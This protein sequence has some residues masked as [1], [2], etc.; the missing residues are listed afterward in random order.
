MVFKGLILDDKQFYQSFSNFFQEMVK[1]LGF[2]DSFDSSN[3][4]QSDSVNNAIRK[5]ENHLR[6]KKVRQT[7]TTTSTFHFPDVDKADIENVISILNSSK[8]G[9]SRTFQ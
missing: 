3:Y 1:T 4:F 8:V 9:I 7:V 6:L 2:S 5:Y